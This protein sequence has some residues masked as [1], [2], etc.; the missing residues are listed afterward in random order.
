[1]FACTRTV[2]AYLD[3]QRYRFGEHMYESV[4][5]QHYVKT[6]GLSMFVCAAAAFQNE[7]RK[8]PKTQIPFSWF[9]SKAV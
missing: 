7:M 3:A 2:S 4:T 8:E 1:M 5:V 6:I 9:A